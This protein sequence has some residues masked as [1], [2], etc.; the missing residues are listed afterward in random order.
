MAARWRVAEVDESGYLRA[1]GKISCELI[2]NN[3]K[4]PLVVRELQAAV[5]APLAGRARDAS[6]SAHICVARAN[7]HSRGALASPANAPVR[8]ARHARAPHQ[9]LAHSASTHQ[10]PSAHAAWCFSVV[11]L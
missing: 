5:A 8:Y 11:S 9:H 7:Q 6:P 2:R 10:I 4:G 1:G 3:K